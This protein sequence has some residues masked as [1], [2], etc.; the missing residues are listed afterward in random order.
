[1]WDNRWLPW[2]EQVPGVRDEMV[3]EARD[4]ARAFCIGLPFPQVRVGTGVRGLSRDHL[5][6]AGSMD[7]WLMSLLDLRLSGR[8]AGLAA[9]YLKA[10][11][12]K[13]GEEDPLLEE[14]SRRV[15]Q[16]MLEPM[17]EVREGADTH[18][19]LIDAAPGIIV[20]QSVRI[21]GRFTF[22][23]LL[24]LYIY[25]ALFGQYLHTDFHHVALPSI[26]KIH[27]GVVMFEEIRRRALEVRSVIDSD[28]VD[29]LI[30]WCLS[31]QEYHQQESPALK[32]CVAY[33][34]AAIKAALGTAVLRFMANPNTSYP[35]IE[36][37][38][39]DPLTYAAIVGEWDP[40]LAAK[41]VDAAVRIGNQTRNRFMNGNGDGLDLYTFRRIIVCDAA[42]EKF[43]GDVLAAARLMKRLHPVWDVCDQ[44]KAVG[45]FDSRGVMAL[46]VA[47]D[48]GNFEASAA[49]G[50]LLC[51]REWEER[52]RQCGLVRNLES[53]IVLICKAVS[54]GDTAAAAD[55]VN[56]LLSNPVGPG[57]AFWQ[58]PH[59][60]VDYSVRCLRNAARQEP[61]ISL[62]LGYLYSL[63][64]RG[65]P[66]DGKAAAV[67]YQS[68]LESISAGPRYQAYAANNLGVLRVFNRSGLNGSISQSRK[69]MDYF[70]MAAASSDSKAESNLAALLCLEGYGSYSQLDLAKETYW[71]CLETRGCNTPLT[72]LQ[73]N[74][75]AMRVTVFELI[76]AEHQKQNFCNDLRWEGMPLEQYGTILSAE[77]VPYA[78]HLQPVDG[79]N[80]V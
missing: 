2:Y 54:V 17:T 11:E 77:T 45:S 19:K 16:T 22:R 31:T 79:Q 7:Q 60:L 8:W 61:S 13:R 62:F 53:G 26:E 47:S 59:S 46:Q 80:K 18:S 27:S 75:E 74:R 39:S 49:Y 32:N 65:V 28:K 34:Q 64:A 1:M 14:T 29:T 15:L 55:L 40:P 51:C 66:V 76:V 6:G 70:K 38:E 73:T 42:R 50:S 52:R 67:S 71:K 78:P 30:D 12:H 9:V 5:A 4:A 44:D 48:K 72:V 43:M 24:E 37:A 33:Q 21:V 69:A 36:I 63:G 58:I 56:L 23:Q 10:V 57:S 35:E 20:T 3:I 68:V 41:I 25:L